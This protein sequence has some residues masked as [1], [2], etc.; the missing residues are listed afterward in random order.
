M[1]LS[2][3]YYLNNIY[4]YQKNHTTSIC[5]NGFAY[6]I[7]ANQDYIKIISIISN[8]NNN[9]L[10]NITNTESLPLSIPTLWGLK[11]KNNINIDN[12]IKKNIL[13]P[14]KELL[15]LIIKNPDINS[16]NCICQD[17]THILTL[18]HIILKINNTEYLFD[19][20]TG[21]NQ[22]WCC[23]NESDLF[24][25]YA[26]I[27]VFREHSILMISQ[28]PKNCEDNHYMDLDLYSIFL[29]NNFIQD[30]YNRFN[31]HN[32]RP[33]YSNLQI[34]NAP[35]NQTLDINNISIETF[36]P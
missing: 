22:T 7:M 18:P 17:Q 24:Y 16:I 12:P 25:S 8:T 11:N 20:W 23:M 30:E 5:K 28:T 35:T 19:N 31:C 13:M 3:N 29:H 1:Y 34:L 6:P 14:K 15:E 21:Y 33:H 26:Y 27:Y 2:I 4:L 32:Y 36:Y 9:D 10:I